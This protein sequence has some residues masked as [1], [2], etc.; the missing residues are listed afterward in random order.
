MVAKRGSRAPIA[1]AAVGAR[2]TGKTGRLS[3]LFRLVTQPGPRSYFTTCCVGIFAT[4]PLLT[5]IPHAARAQEIADDKVEETEGL[6]IRLVNRTGTFRDTDCYWSLDDG[7]QWHSF[8]DEPS[9]VRPRSSGRMYFRIGT[10]PRNFE[11]REAHWDY[12]KYGTWD[13]RSW[14][15]STS[16]VEG[17]CI[18][19]TVEMGTKKVGIDE[20]RRTLFDKFRLEAP[21]VFKAC[22]LQDKWIVAPAYLPSFKEGGA[23]GKYF[24][25]Y[26]DEVWAKY[27]S[28]QKTPSGKWIG[29][30]TDGALTFTP[31]MGS[32]EPLTCPRKPTT[33]EVLLG[34][35]IMA[36]NRAFCAAINRHVL[37]DPADWENPAAYYQA[38]PCN[39]YAKFFH[40]HSIG[41]KA[42]AFRHDDIAQQAAY[43]SGKGNEVV[44]TLYWEGAQ[45]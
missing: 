31:V 4:V 30:V 8:A 10:A 37:A 43:F 32:G 17:F 19:M 28:E 36:N 39:W 34:K 29:K 2:I 18:P 24:D 6:P 5:A 15:C 23:S 45:K 11:D 25:A 7:K 9:M 35:N 22:V 13:P 41:R 14:E 20:S 44:I 16:Q 12:I 26:I 3:N 1:E 27:A 21:E 38:E 42:F 33:Q 40:E